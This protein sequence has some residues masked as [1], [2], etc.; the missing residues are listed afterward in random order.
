MHI[1]REVFK[2][3]LKIFIWYIIFIKISNNIYFQGSSFVVRDH[4][5]DE[6]K[7]VTPAVECVQ[8]VGSLC[9]QQKNTGYKSE[10]TDE[11]VS[12]TYDSEDIAINDNIN[13][14]LNPVLSYA[15]TKGFR[16]CDIFYV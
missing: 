6:V 2:V 1:F 5:S 10:A 13:L 8:K 9:I 14:E 16:N 12:Q 7:K 4:E 11:N 3:L 15:M